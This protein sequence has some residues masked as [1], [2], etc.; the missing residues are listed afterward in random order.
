MMKKMETVQDEQGLKSMLTGWYSRLNNLT[1]NVIDRLNEWLEKF[2]KQVMGALRQRI[3][4]KATDSS[5]RIF[6]FFEQLIAKAL[7]RKMRHITADELQQKLRQKDLQKRAINRDESRKSFQL[8]NMPDLPD[9]LIAQFAVPDPIR[10][11][12]VLLLR[13]LPTLQQETWWKCGAIS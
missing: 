4:I 9:E 1:E 8:I 3:N 11:R 5:Q 7:H 2:E 10:P 6:T 13:R 12:Q